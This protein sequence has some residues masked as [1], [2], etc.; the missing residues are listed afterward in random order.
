M[1]R[2]TSTVFLTALLAVGAA[3]CDSGG[4]PSRTSNPSASAS[5]SRQQLLALGQEWVQCLRDHGLTRMPDAELSPE[6]Y[7][8]FPPQ[9]GYDWKA[10]LTNRPRIVDACRSIEDRYPPSAFRPRQQFSAEDLRKLAE[11]AKCMREHGVPEFPDPNADGGFDLTGTS[12]ANGN[13]AQM[14]AANQA[15]KHIWSGEIRINGG[16]GK[17]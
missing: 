10:D 13:P 2:T 17:K 9:N 1:T 15:C 8:Q 11:Y 12:L 6:G 7:L 14:A 4:P 16:G 5:A 3:G